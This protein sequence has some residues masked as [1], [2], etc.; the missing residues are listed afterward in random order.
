VRLELSRLRDVCSDQLVPFEGLWGF[1][2][3]LDSYPGTIFRFP[4]R[5][6]KKSTK[7][8]LRNSKNVF[9][10][11]EASVLLEAY[12]DEARVSLLFL[13][14]IKS[15]DFSVHGHPESGWSVTRV[16]SVKE[17]AD[18][19][20]TSVKCQYTRNTNSESP[21]IGQD[22]WW[23]SVKGLLPDADRLPKTTRRS[24]KNVECGMA[25]LISST[26][27]SQNTDATVPKVIQ[28]RMFSTLPLPIS[29]DLPVYVHATFLL[30]GDR[31]SLAI[32]EYGI[33]AQEAGWN[34]YLLQEHLPKLYLSFLEDIGP[35]VCQR[36]FSFWPQEEPPKRSCAEVLCTSF[37]QQLPQSSQRLFPK[38]QPIS[39]QSQFSPLEALDVSQ[40]VFD[41]LP[42]TQS[43]ALAPLL[44]AMH[45]NL[46]GDIPGKV[47]TRLETVPGVKSITSPML[48]ALF[49]SAQS[50]TCLLKVMAT[51]IH[52]QHILE[53]LFDLLIPVAAA[54]YKDLDGCHILPLADGTIDTLKFQDTDSVFSS[55]YFV[56]TEDELKLFK[57][58]S[59]HLVT[60]TTRKLLARVLDSGKFNLTSLKLC[61]VK[62][63]LEMKPEIPTP[64]EDEDKWL[65]EFW[66]Y[67]DGHLDSSRS[68]LN[69]DDLNANIFRAILD[70]EP[71][72]ASPA[73]FHGLP[74]VVEPLIGDHQKLCDKFPN[75]WRFDDSFMPKSLRNNEMSFN[76]QDS[77]YRFIR[78]LRLLSGQITIGPYVK[79]CLSVVELKVSSRYFLRPCCR[80]RWMKCILTQRLDPSESC[81][82]SRSQGNIDP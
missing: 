21:V 27:D 77:F 16:Q 41:F 74:A 29:S 34:R 65:Q 40:A 37:W 23:V 81:D 9:N 47:A 18:L 59:R 62:K 39:E 3:A 60:P 48:R 75:L 24:M 54:E 20:S 50:G 44:M 58:A 19:S 76:S 32:D 64:T 1:T 66:K 52:H 82:I 8:V 12:F 31:Q 67:W 5:R 36:V 71:L 45:V 26:I 42:K 55:R 38:S 49:K 17:D 73:R 6:A 79:S 63:L 78:S 51:D 22:K 43:E 72:Y 70:G 25:A 61:D 56:V 69:I 46:V 4:F 28:S 68:E 15:I 2:Q 57:F 30:S 35:Q 10:D 80:I 33:N 7:S 14:R 53:V 13:R 11:T